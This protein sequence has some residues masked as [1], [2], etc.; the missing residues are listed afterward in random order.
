MNRR[1][2][3]MLGIAAVLLAASMPA[4]AATPAEARVGSL[5][6][7]EGKAFVDGAA[8]NGTQA[9]YPIVGTGQVLST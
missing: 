9:T 3:R 7:V 6:Y 8:V 4:R 5:D 2:F 1:I